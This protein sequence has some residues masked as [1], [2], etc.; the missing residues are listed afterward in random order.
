M[1]RI[2]LIIILAVVIIY[3]VFRS[4]K[5]RYYDTPSSESAIDILKKRYAKGEISKE[6]F[7]RMK[8][9]LRS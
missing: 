2:W 5:P 6:E 9:D 7:E 8:N 1:L 4:R 3:V